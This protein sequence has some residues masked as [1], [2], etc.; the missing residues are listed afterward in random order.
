VFFPQCDR[1]DFKHI[2]NNKSSSTIS[3]RIL[4]YGSV[5]A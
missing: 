5:L 3:C 2:Q 1:P 4:W